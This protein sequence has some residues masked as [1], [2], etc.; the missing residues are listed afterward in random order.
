MPTG[1][2]GDLLPHVDLKILDQGTTQRS[3][4]LK[5]FLRSLAV[6]GALDLIQRIDP[7]HDLDRNWRE[8]NVLFA[9]GLATRILFNIGHSEERAARMRPA[10]GFPDWSRIAPSQIELVM[11]VIGVSLQDAS[12]SRQMPLGMLALAIAG[13]VEHR[14]RRARSTK[15]PIIS[16]VNPASP[17]VGL[18]LGQH[19]H[20]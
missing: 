8:R 10:R 20:G 11:P 15:R 2:L 9:S 1:K 3:P 17:R 5:T 16:H 7:T 6:D 14:R 4:N 19:R 18:P 12:I 13:V